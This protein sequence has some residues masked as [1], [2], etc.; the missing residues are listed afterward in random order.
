MGLLFFVQ[1]RLIGIAAVFVVAERPKVMCVA[2][3]VLLFY[4]LY[5]CMF[6]L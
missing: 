6:N 3:N 1:G 2:M 4:T 5:I